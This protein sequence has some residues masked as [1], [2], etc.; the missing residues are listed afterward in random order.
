MKKHIYLI[1]GLAA[2]PSIFKNIQLPKE[3]KLHYLEWLIPT[4]EHESL[5]DYT[6]RMATFIT[7]PSPILIGVSF[8]GIIAQEISKIIPIK[9]II[10]ISSIKLDAELPVH[11]ALIKKTKAYKLLPSKWIS[12]ID[13]L[14][15]YVF[16]KIAKSRA[17]L[18]KEHLSV[19]NEIYLNWGVYQVLHWQ[20]K[21]VVP[22]VTHIQGTKDSVFP[23]QNIKNYIPIE[24]GTHIMILSKA[25]KI[26]KLLCE[27]LE[28]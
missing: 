22:N 25:K 23:A 17:K 18:Y 4:S 3:Y 16:G 5:K 8:G 7:H 27:I 20:Q 1:P 14:S 26:V 10:I 2:G 24:N 15:P 19:R 12:N 13:D 11:L 21:E 6:K 9:K 28:E